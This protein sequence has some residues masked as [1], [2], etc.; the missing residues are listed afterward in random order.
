MRIGFDI[1]QTGTGKAGCGYFADSLAR[2]LAQI[3]RDNE[4]ILYPTFGDFYFDDS[5][6]VFCPI[7][8]GNVRYGL[9]HKLL[10]KAQHFWRYPPADYETQ[11][12]HPDIIH[13]NNYFCPA[14]LQKARLVYTLYDLG[15]VENPEWT[16]EE[17]RTGCFNG[18]FNA[19]LYSDFIVAISEYSRRHFLDIFP[20]Y[21]AERIAV[22]YPASRFSSP[23]TFSKPGSLDALQ[24]EKFWL[25]VGTLEPRKNHKRLIQAYARLKAHAGKAF[26]LVL[27]GSEGWLMEDF[28]KE[29]DDLGLR[30]DIILLGYVDDISLQWLYQNCFAALYPSLYEGFGLPVLEAMTLG[31][32][33]ITTNSTS[34]P[35]IVG[36][37]AILIDPMQ[38]E[39]IFQAMLTLSSNQTYRVTLREEALQQAKNF[40]WERAAKEILEIYRNLVQQPKRNPSAI[41]QT[42]NEIIPL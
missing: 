5:M 19:S 23:E 28:R 14:K 32:P 39:E 31:A 25:S 38:E 12:G 11:I 41:H 1:S 7:R 34:I 10:D 37:S 42:H 33:V 13:A 17:N 21:P 40:S 22:V 9:R 26:P 15:F 16:T 4:Y 36:S 8:Q 3:D 27:A 20:H 24:A 2:S 18:V 35:E 6:P 30:Q 29:I